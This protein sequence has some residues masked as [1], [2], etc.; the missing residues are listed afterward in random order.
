MSDEGEWA[1]HQPRDGE[2]IL[3]CAC[4]GTKGP[5]YFW[6]FGTSVKLQYEDGGSLDIWWAWACEECFNKAEGHVA[7]VSFVEARWVG[8]KP[9]VKA[10][11]LH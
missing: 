5:F 1:E 6:H 2:L 11:V 3:R 4:G 9:A 8:D 7:R 10:K